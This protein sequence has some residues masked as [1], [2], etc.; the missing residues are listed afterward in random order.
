MA[1]LVKVAHRGA[2]GKFPE[3]TRLAFEK[4]IEAG[5]DMIELDCQLTEDGHV[6]IF[7]DERLRRIAGSRGRVRAKTL[8][9][10]KR[11]DLGASEEPSFRGGHILT[12]EAAFVH[13][14]GKP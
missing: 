10:L 7:H 1:G 2:S 5:A 14:Q 9:E 13:L 11:L 3:N 4:A 6:V 12:L 8:E